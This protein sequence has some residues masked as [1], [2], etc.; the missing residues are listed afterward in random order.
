MDVLRFLCDNKMYF[1]YTPFRRKSSC[2]IIL[3]FCSISKILVFQIVRT[4]NRVD[5]KWI[6][7]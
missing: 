5:N 1:T 3:S 2:T 4:K 7:N 6:K